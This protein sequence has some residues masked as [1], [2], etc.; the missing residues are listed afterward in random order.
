LDGLSDAN[1]NRLLTDDIAFT[2]HFEGLNEV[3]GLKGMLKDV[4]DANEST[5]NEILDLREEALTIKAESRALQMTLRR[6]RDEYEECLSMARGK[7]GFSVGDQYSSS[8]IQEISAMVLSKVR[9]VEAVG[10]DLV[11]DFHRGDI[12]FREFS[13]QFRKCRQEY[14]ELTMKLHKLR[15]GGI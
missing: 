6:V 2:I 14:H 15:E 9:H 4:E 7:L 3:K 11:S 5:A 13:K 12:E 1:L 10:E 8:R